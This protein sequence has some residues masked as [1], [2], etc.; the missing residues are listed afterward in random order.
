M[1][2]AIS[3][4]LLAGLLCVGAQAFADD[5]TNVTATGDST[6]KQSQALKDCLAKQKAKGSTLSTA[7][8]TKAC[9]EGQ[10]SPLEKDNAAPTNETQTTIPKA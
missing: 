10:T 3:S 7:D 6:T 4:A 9:T 5:T 8:M 1:N 2:R